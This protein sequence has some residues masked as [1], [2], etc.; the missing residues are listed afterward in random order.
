MKPYETDVKK[1]DEGNKRVYIILSME[2]EDIYGK[3]RRIKRA[4]KGISREIN[5]LKK[6]YEKASKISEQYAHDYCFND[7]EVKYDGKES[8]IFYQTLTTVQDDLNRKRNDNRVSK[9][10]IKAGAAVM[11][12]LAGDFMASDYDDSETKPNYND[13]KSTP[14]FSTFISSAARGAG[15]VGFFLNPILGF[16]LYGGGTLGIAPKVY[17][18]GLGNIKKIEGSRDG[19]FD[20]EAYMKRPVASTA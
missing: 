2:A 17:K 18:K 12:P 6:D 8:D 19:E 3:Y 9:E 7:F 14:S 16:A 10:I 4:V 5:S 20:I 1:T 15:F 11:I 13:S